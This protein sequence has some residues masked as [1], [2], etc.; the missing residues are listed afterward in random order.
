MPAT[1]TWK[2]DRARLARLSQDLPA[3]HPDLVELRSKL[4]GKRLTE[5]IEKV[6]A[7]ARRH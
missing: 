1:T 6:L 5:Y 7:E 3:K 2:Q 4:R